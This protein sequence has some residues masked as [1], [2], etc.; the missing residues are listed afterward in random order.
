[1]AVLAAITGG[2]FALRRSGRI[3]ATIGLLGL[4]A[5]P[6]IAVYGFL[7]YLVSHP[8]DWR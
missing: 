8:I 1:M 4:S 3:G 5:L 7:L 2:A 6:T